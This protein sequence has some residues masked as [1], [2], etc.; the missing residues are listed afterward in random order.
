MRTNIT[1]VMVT[2]SSCSGTCLTLSMPRQ[3]KV[4]AAESALSS[5][6]FTRSKLTIA[7]NSAALSVATLVTVTALRLCYS[8][9]LFAEWGHDGRY[10]VAV[11]L[12]ALVG[13]PLF[14]IQSWLIST[15][16]Q[17]LAKKMLKTKIVTMA[18]ALDDGVT[19]EPE[20]D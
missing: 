14:V 6:R 11:G 3:P 20:H 16:G 13:L 12:M 10:I 1:G 2:S 8:S 9:E 15:T 7:Y 5:S 4:S 17:S 19:G 18:G